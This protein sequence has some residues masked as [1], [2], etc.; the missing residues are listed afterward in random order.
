VVVGIDWSLVHKEGEWKRRH[1]LIDISSL[2]T[3]IYGIAMQTALVEDDPEAGRGH[4]RV[5]VVWEGVQ[6]RMR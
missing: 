3:K 6:R 2:A 1:F 4:A 5:Q